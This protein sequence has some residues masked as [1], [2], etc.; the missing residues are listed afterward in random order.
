MAHREQ[1]VLITGATR[2]IGRAAALALARRGHRVVAT[3]RNAELLASLEREAGE[4]RLPMAVWP[5]DVTDGEAADATVSRTVKEL[6]RVDALVNNAGYG[7]WGPLEL[8]TMDE[9]RRLFE[10]NVFATLRLSQAVLPHMRQSRSGTIVNV[11][12][13]SG[14][15]GNPAGGAYSGTKFALRA[16]SVIMRQEVAQFGVRV[17]LVEP[18]L[19][20]TDFHENQVTGQGAQD[21]ASPYAANLERVRARL[22]RSPYAGGDPRRVADIVRKAIEK[23]RPK[24]R[25]TVGPDAWAAAFAARFVPDGFVG[26]ATKRVLGW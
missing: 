19:F 13:A 23:R 8:L 21:P 5:L 20:R 12:S 4:A 1:V 2:G 9:V 11:G 26:W 14:Q 25:Y 17:V 6:G 18:G 3:G 10:T 7:L 15:I 22:D 16:M 24:A